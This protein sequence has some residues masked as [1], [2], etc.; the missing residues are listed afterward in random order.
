[1]GV[2][3]SESLVKKTLGFLL[4]VWNEK[5]VSESFVWSGLDHYFFLTLNTDFTSDAKG[6]LQAIGGGVCGGL[7]N[8]ALQILSW[9]RI[10]NKNIRTFMIHGW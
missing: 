10:D 9:I 8:K 6:G 1:M 5:V 7:G 3:L 4:K 2:K